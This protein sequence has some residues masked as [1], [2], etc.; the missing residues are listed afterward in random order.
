MD[1]FRVS[2]Q[3]VA[4]V[5]GADEPGYRLALRGGLPPNSF[6]SLLRGRPFG[7]IV[8]Q[9]VAAVGASL[10]LAPALCTEPF[11]EPIDVVAE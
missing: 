7:R 10:G 3:F 2:Q 1:R 6:S 11:P 5:R 8:R 9:R 4:A